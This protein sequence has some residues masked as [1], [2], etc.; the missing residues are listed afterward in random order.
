MLSFSLLPT[1]A[2]VVT[3]PA[4]APTLAQ[5]PNRAWASASSR[6]SPGSGVGKARA[7][8]SRPQPRA[9]PEV[10][11]SAAHK[12]WLELRASGRPHPTP[13]Q[14]REGVAAPGSAP[15]PRRAAESRRVG[16][17]GAG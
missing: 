8:A 15:R 1:K 17:G 16:A 10:E 2:A 14:P 3:A 6:S 13:V 5:H 7:E 9:A 11:G 4:T 12:A